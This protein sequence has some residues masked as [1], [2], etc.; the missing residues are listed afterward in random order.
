MSKKE[1]AEQKLLKIIE[2]GAKEEN[3]SASADQSQDSQQTEHVAQEIAS[4]VKGSGASG[5]S[6]I[7]DFSEKLRGFNFSV[8]NLKSIGLK[9][10]N[11][12]LTAMI[13]G[14]V[15]FLGITYQ[16][17]NKKLSA[18]LN[19][20][21]NITKSK[22]GSGSGIMPS[23]EKLTSFLETILRRNIFR[24]YEQKESEVAS[25]AP[26][27]TQRVA[28]KLESLKLVGISWLDIPGSA[29]AMVE[30]A[31]GM[32]FFLKEGENI[33]QVKIK[34]IYADR[35]IFSFEDQEMEIRL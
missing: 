11:L 33:N 31:E 21:K 27:G 13:I 8:P 10:A 9:E 30:N 34:K 16:G 15:L 28:A 5:S 35:V 18:N 7:S 26:I 24:P 17:E 3:Q 6:I 19:F 14:S 2:D 32:T 29:S 23:Y 20:V 1:T 22:F 12:V 4:A 25:N